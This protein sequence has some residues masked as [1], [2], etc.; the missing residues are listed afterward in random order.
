MTNYFHLYNM[1][2]HGT[3]VDENWLKKEGWGKIFCDDCFNRLPTCLTVNIVV[4]SSKIKD[5][6]GS[7]GIPN[8]G[9]AKKAV[10]DALKPEVDKVLNLGTISN[11]EGVVLSDVQTFASKGRRV[12]VRGYT[13]LDS[14]L[15]TTCAQFPV[16]GEPVGNRYV[17][18]KRQLVDPV[19]ESSD[20]S[21]IV[22]EDLLER[23]RKFLDERV[24]VEKLALVSQG[25]DGRTEPE[26]E[27]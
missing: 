18:T 10:L 23:I 20:C 12:P 11:P 3:S 5:V 16:D 1:K 19:Y 4:T 9:F 7:F 8:V 2:N 13:Y 26:L 27:F 21:L 25:Y 24:L 6:T 22:R 15:C 14:E 17:V